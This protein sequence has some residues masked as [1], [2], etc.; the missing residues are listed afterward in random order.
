MLGFRRP[1]T[2]GTARCAGGEDLKS[3]PAGLQEVCP[4]L[5]KT[6]AE[7]AVCSVLEKTGSR[8]GR[9]AESAPRRS[10][11]GS[12]PRSAILGSASPLPER[13]PL[14]SREGQTRKTGPM[15]TYRCARR[16]S[17]APRYGGGG[18]LRLTGSKAAPASFFR[19]RED[20]SYPRGIWPHHHS[21]SAEGRIDRR[22]VGGGPSIVRIRALLREFHSSHCP[23]AEE[24]A[25]PERSGIA[26][27]L[28]S[29]F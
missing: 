26:S 14:F 8:P 27:I 4:L 29:F 24:S 10:G 22:K 3:V 16:A 6:G 25:L 11:A 17:A 13:P 28:A 18:C 7:G 5:E 1:D 2:L 23:T 15:R 12:D 9:R 19:A 20:A 21:R